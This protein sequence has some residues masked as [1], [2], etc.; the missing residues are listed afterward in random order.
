MHTTIQKRNVNEG[1]YYFPDFTQNVLNRVKLG[2]PVFLTGPSGTGKTEFVEYLAT[3]ENKKLH[4][5]DFS[6]GTTESNIV[7]RLLIEDVETKFYKGLL[8][9]AMI[10]GDW[11]LLDEIDFAEPEHLAILQQ[12][13]MGKPLIITQNKS[14]VIYPHPD[15][16]I[17]ATANTKGRG[18]ETQSYAGTNV[19]NISFID[20]FSIF[21]FDYTKKEATILK[22]IL[23]DKILA[24]NFISLFKLLRKATEQ[25]EIIN[26]IFS[27]RRLIQVAK[28]LNLG[29]TFK[30]VV[31]HEI[32]NR[33]ERSEKALIK[34]YIFE[35]FDKEHYYKDWK[36]GNEHIAVVETV[37]GTEDKE[38]Y[39]ED[40]DE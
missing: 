28:L 24:D 15:F 26:A 19:L 14:E 8:P 23:A 17:F 5:I 33:F 10:N 6:V 11:L 32:I 12:V 38:A 31:D 36:L 30:E 35:V 18:D 22:E 1:L 4:E 20:R 3:A 13:L 2:T 9:Q 7:G 16:R 34:E 21:E 37:V 40:D 25:E 39:E 27:T 29:E